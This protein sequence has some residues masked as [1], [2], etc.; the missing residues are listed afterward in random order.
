ML[1]TY[2]R[3]ENIMTVWMVMNQKT[4]DPN[5]VLA[6]YRRELERVL[7]ETSR[8]GRLGVKAK[9]ILRDYDLGA[10]MAP[11]MMVRKL[12]EKGQV[13]VIAERAH[14]ERAAVASCFVLS[15]TFLRQAAR[16]ILEIM[17]PRTP[18]HSGRRPTSV[19]SSIDAMCR[20]MR[21]KG[22]RNERTVR[23]YREGMMCVSKRAEEDGIPL[24]MPWDVTEGYL[25]T[26]LE[27]W[28]VRGYTVSTRKDYWSAVRQWTLVFGNR[29]TADFYVAWPAD[30]RPNVDWLSKQEARDLLARRG[31]PTEDLIVHCELCLGMRRVELL[32]LR[33]SDFHGDYV[34]ILGK[35]RN[36]GKPRRM[37]YHRD[38]ERVLERYLEYRT[39]LVE[40][41]PDA[42]GDDHLLLWEHGAKWG[43]YG[44][45]GT[46]IDGILERLGD[47]IGYEGHLSSHTLRRTFGRAMYH[48]GVEPATIA[49]MLGHDSIDTTLKY[50]GVDMDDMADAMR[51]FG[52]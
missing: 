43:T 30:M 6:I 24:P 22:G 1:K 7:T 28:K 40:R 20:V 49:K 47:E 17:P 23:F 37:P 3:L 18:V 29:V 11:D 35:G 33:L 12:V 16:R 15:A 32:R 51:R 8:N 2:D 39:E 14:G 42:R 52:L 41:H 45:K 38:T 36:G 5:E 19:R 9:T 21:E 13:A 10:S 25:K 31:T 44:A 4:D 50:I 48:S 34:D 27:S 26:L 46:G